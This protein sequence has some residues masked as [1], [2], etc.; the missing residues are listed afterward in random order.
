MKVIRVDPDNPD[1][2][3]IA[4]A[5]ALVRGGRLVA[6]PT[7]TVYGLGGDALDPIAL[8]RIF[9][10]K[11]RPH[12]N[13]LIAHFLD[14][15]RAMEFA[16]VWPDDAVALGAVFWPGPLTL[17]VRK[18][19]H[20]P[21]RL[22]AGLD[23][24]AVRVPSH[25]VARA[26]LAAADRAIAAPS[27]NRFTEL[28]PT[29][30]AHVV[31]GLTG[32]VD[33]V[34]DAGPTTLGIESTVIDVSGEKATV[35]RPGSLTKTQL[36]EVLGREI[37][38]AGKMAEHAARP[39]PGMAER[40]YS[41][42]APLEMIPR[43]PS[44]QLQE[45]AAAAAAAGR[46]VGALLLDLSADESDESIGESVGM[47]LDPMG[48]ARGLYA[49][50]HRLDDAGCDLILVEE[51]PSGAEWSGVRDRLARAAHPK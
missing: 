37:E 39:S 51:I 26:L 24:V 43:I 12:G 47:P 16:A 29:T 5:A 6:F 19:T 7:E 36:E 31:K 27:A 46:I 21:A 50:L 20:I 44:G 35:L 30:A 45:R 14:S 18:Q 17:V 40:H 33:L 28:S 1:E 49:A 2:Q 8:D 13:P 25:P 42:R 15:G 48:Y 22:T 32:Q 23:T 10:A 38:L 11:R 4:E 3:S 34:L 41:P 9:A